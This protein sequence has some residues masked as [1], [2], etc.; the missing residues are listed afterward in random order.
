MSFIQRDC[1]GS[2]PGTSLDSYIILP[3]QRIPRYELFFRQLIK[4][5]PALTGLD[6]GDPSFNYALE[7][8]QFPPES[9]EAQLLTT[10][11]RISGLCMLVNEAKRRV[12]NLQM[13]LAAQ[14][15]CQGIDLMATS[16]TFIREGKLVKKSGSMFTPNSTRVFFL[17]D[18]MI[19]WS[20]GKSCTLN[21]SD[22]SNIAP[23][24]YFCQ[25]YSYCLCACQTGCF[26]CVLP[27]IL[28]RLA[29]RHVICPLTS[30]P[31]SPSSPSPSAPSPPDRGHIA[32]DAS[33]VVE[34]LTTDAR[35]RSSFRI[36]SP[37][38]TLVLTASSDQECA[39]WVTDLHAQ[40]AYA[41]TKGVSPLSTKPSPSQSQS[42]LRQ[43]IGAVGPLSSPSETSSN[44]R[45][46]TP[47][48]QEY[49]HFSSAYVTGNATGN[50]T[51]SGMGGGEG[52]SP[53]SR[54]RSRADSETGSLNASDDFNMRN[55][56]HQGAGGKRPPK[57]HSMQFLISLDEANAMIAQQNADTSLSASATFGSAGVGGVGPSP[58]PA[59]FIDKTGF[60][61][62][63][64]S[65]SSSSP[66]YSAADD[67]K[68]LSRLH[69]L[70]TRR[71][72]DAYLE[73]QSQMN[74]EAIEAALQA[75][76]AMAK[77][78]A[79]ANGG[80]MSGNGLPASGLTVNPEVGA[81][82]PSASC[83]SS[84]STST[85]A[86]ST[87]TQGDSH[88]DSNNS[89]A[90]LQS[91]VSPVNSHLIS[92]LEKAFQRNS[93][94]KH[95]VDAQMITSLPDLSREMQFLQTRKQEAASAASSS[96]L[97]TSS[98]SSQASA[99]SLISPQFPEQLPSTRTSARLRA[100][101]ARALVQETTAVLA[102]LRRREQ[103]AISS[104]QA[105]MEQLM[106]VVKQCES[107][108]SAA[109]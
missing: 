101:Q 83:S 47:L 3:V 102:E 22:R 40:I 48:H 35:S 65:S 87:S 98:T 58:A 72:S 84:T 45:S 69:L 107:K 28:K 23:G 52:D 7:C 19:V 26:L 106:T 60:P 108:S 67:A 1:G 36:A 16:R 18:D 41:R 77:A 39:A 79:A 32:F 24:S 109:R 73:G 31:L 61:S 63:S 100:E 74:D 13:V 90:A 6:L 50:V 33:T 54:S 30:S 91:L 38:K 93:H 64:S 57:R 56:T 46:V 103:E 34:L 95:L 85:S 76:M 70:A 37:S 42:H 10:M 5:T 81:T 27:V 75:G 14:T 92:G 104:V 82:A 80:S 43:G 17:F 12:H 59:A 8:A 99:K 86:S 20:D 4:L 53:R 66:S 44:S 49:P 94:L 68:T 9:E 29:P 55:H 88:Y 97:L 96:A 25:L 71:G 105:M 2:L 11:E 89:Q 21:S 51:G 78:A 15:Q 62:S